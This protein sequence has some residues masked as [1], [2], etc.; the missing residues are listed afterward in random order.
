VSD[1]DYLPLSWEQV[2][3]LRREAE[4]RDRT[5][6]QHVLQVPDYPPLSP[7]PEC[8][9]SSERITSWMDIPK[10]EDPTDRMLIRFDPC[11]HRFAAVV[12]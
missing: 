11:G 2:Q 7:C 6:V 10:F 8:G 5:I 9:A 3:T 4:E 12:E 1:A